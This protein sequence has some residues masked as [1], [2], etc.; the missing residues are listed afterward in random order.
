M[1]AMDRHAH[2]DAAQ[3]HCVTKDVVCSGDAVIMM[4][5]VLQVLLFAGYF[6][7]VRMRAT[8]RKFKRSNQQLGCDATRPA[9]PRACRATK[10]S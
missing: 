2:A 1:H 5:W 3:L 4:R 10:R 8:Q 9:R 6:L 7:M